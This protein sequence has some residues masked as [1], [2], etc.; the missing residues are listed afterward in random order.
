M[1]SIEGFRA[2]ID[3]IAHNGGNFQYKKDSVW[4]D[5]DFVSHGY[6]CDL[7]TFNNY[8]WDK[9]RIGKKVL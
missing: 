2:F 6:D 1:T 4:I 3:V 7:I 9:L 5:C 8:Q